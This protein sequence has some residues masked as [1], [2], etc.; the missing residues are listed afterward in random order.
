[1]DTRESEA[2]VGQR[3]VGGGGGGGEGA[4]RGNTK[5]RDDLV[6]LGAWGTG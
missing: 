5:R 2:Q 4:G 1:M 6:I 3:K